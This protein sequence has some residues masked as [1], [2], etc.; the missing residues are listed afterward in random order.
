MAILT[1]A[2]AILANLPLLR[3]RPWRELGLLALVL[4]ETSWIAL[5]YDSLPLTGVV[6]SFPQVYFTLGGFFLLALALAYALNSMK[7]DLTLQRRILLGVLLVSLVAG[8]KVLLY[9]H[10]RLGLAEI[11]SRPVRTFADFS[12]LV[13]A[14]FIALLAVG[15]VWWRGVELAQKHLEPN[16][17]LGSFRTGVLV[18]WGYGLLRRQLD[19]TSG[20]ALYIFLS[21]GLLAMSTARIS[22][23]SALRGGRQARFDRAWMLGLFLAACGVAALGLLVVG[24]LQDY[25]AAALLEVYR[26]AIA[27]LG[28]LFYALIIPPLTLLLNALLALGRWGR[29]SEFLATL[30]DLANRFLQFVQSLFG[31]ETQ[32]FEFRLPFV[33]P[34]VLW[35]VLIFIILMILAALTIRVGRHRLENEE[36]E[37]IAGRAEMLEQFRQSLRKRL[38]KMR[39]RLAQL[40]RWRRPGQLLAAARVRRIY[41]NLMRLSSRLGSPRPES[42]TPLEFLPTL[43]SLFP[44]LKDD[45]ADITAAYLR[46]RYGEL[47]ETL[48]EVEL[49]EAAWRRV[50]SAGR[51]K[52]SA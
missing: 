32:D 44:D 52:L 28:L 11:L 12:G 10:E 47:S 7:L 40:S 24:L 50:L 41:W 19:Q 51:T 17:V 5:C 37:Q 30:S 42:L 13:P 29:I 18:F 36:T 6:S 33:K 26:V 31:P 9:A 48:Q 25:A 1:S 43:A 45:L 22:A 35:S 16:V 49:V 4:M 34:L 46:V 21:A 23:L 8:L 15:L 38:Q 27:V 20:V 39:D 14:E 2:K 3:L